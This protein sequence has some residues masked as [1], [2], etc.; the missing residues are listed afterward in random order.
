MPSASPRSL[1]VS[2]PN[3]SSRPHARL[4]LERLLLRAGA[5]RSARRSQAW[6]CP[7]PTGFGASGFASS[8]RGRAAA[9]QRRW[10]RRRRVE[11]D[12]PPIALLGQL[13][14]QE[15]RHEARCDED[16]RVHVGDTRATRPESRLR[17]RS[18][19]PGPGREREPL[20][21]R[22]S[23]SIAPRLRPGAA[24]RPLAHLG[25]LSTRLGA[26]R[27][28][29][30]RPRAAWPVPIRLKSRSG[31][32]NARGETTSAAQAAR[33]GCVA[34]LPAAAYHQFTSGTAMKSV[35]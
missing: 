34:R 5:S 19:R 6:A 28:G 7:R 30:P 3:W 4:G 17:S 29:D 26:D 10:R 24:C 18:V 31:A 11:E 15:D 20:A 32:F 16:D 8:G 12:D 9:L 22:W 21:K 23:S 2:L 14:G 25:H 13:L 27:D 1:P 35:E 33:A